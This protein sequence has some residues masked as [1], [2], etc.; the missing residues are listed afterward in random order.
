MVFQVSVDG[1]ISS[2]LFE[3]RPS[4][5]DDDQNLRCEARN[6]QIPDIVQQDHWTLHVHCEYNIFYVITLFIMTSFISYLHFSTFL[7]VS[8]AFRHLV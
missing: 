2:S 5:D 3:F 8:K 6:N 4:I 1:N 7:L